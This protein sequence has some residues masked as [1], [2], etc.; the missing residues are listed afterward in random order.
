MKM[1]RSMSEKAYNCR[2]LQI[3]FGKV[4]RFYINY[5]VKTDSLNT[6]DYFEK[7]LNKKYIFY[8]SKGGLATLFRVQNFL[9][10]SFNNSQEQPCRKP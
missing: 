1:E 3:Q 9:R 10:S 6:E 8:N 7:I 5:S 2:N 4:A